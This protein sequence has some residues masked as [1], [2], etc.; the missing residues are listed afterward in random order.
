MLRLILGFLVVLPTGSGALACSPLPEP[1]ATKLVQ[2]SAANVDKAKTTLVEAVVVRSAR[3]PQ[4]GALRVVRVHW[5]KAR[6]GAV[7][8]AQPQ[9]G[10]TCGPGRLTVGEA[11]YV[12]LSDRDL[13]LHPLPFFGFMQPRQ[14]K[15]YKARG[16]ILR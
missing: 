5:G 6:E 3:W 1:I 2:E 14:V 9:P 13:R 10:S 4:S 15:A 11:G 8:V 16:L 7:I 12:Q